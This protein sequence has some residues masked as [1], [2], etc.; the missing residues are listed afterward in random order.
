MGPCP[1]P[2]CVPRWRCPV[3]ARRELVPAGENYF[4][5]CS[6]GVEGDWGGPKRHWTDPSSEGSE[7]G[8]WFSNAAA[9][10]GT[11]GLSGVQSASSGQRESRRR[12]RMVACSYASGRLRAQVQADHGIRPGVRM[13]TDVLGSVVRAE[14]G[15]DQCGQVYGGAGVARCAQSGV[16]EV[17]EVDSSNGRLPCQA[18]RCDPFGPWPLGSTVWTG[19]GLACPGSWPCRMDEGSALACRVYERGHRPFGPCTDHLEL[20]RASNTDPAAG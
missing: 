20:R 1:Q 4:R 16:D 18:L 15:T 12:I 17:H 13:D 9:M 6:E 3:L 19:R 14:A 8:G 7:M 11:S 2:A 5:R 10:S